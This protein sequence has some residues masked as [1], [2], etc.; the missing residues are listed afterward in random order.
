MKA[1][2][3]FVEETVVVKK[4][5]KVMVTDDATAEEIEQAIRQEAYKTLVSHKTGWEIQDSQSVLVE[6]N[7]GEGGDE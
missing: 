3:G 4:R 6:W 2:S 7:N 5:V 1:V